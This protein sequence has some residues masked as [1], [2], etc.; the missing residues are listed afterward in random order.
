MP[1]S[2]SNLEK[3]D[4]LLIYGECGKNAVRS[5]NLYAERYPE[6]PTPNRK[7]FDRLV[8][9]LI[10]TGSFELKRNNNN[11]LPV[12]NDIN[13]AMVLNMV[14]N[15]PHTSIRE[16]SGATGKYAIYF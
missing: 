16:I 6:R 14:E 4:M 5:V 7:I 13:Q 3:V 15:D 11:N 12:N 2:Y 10:E 1:F 8:T 9:T